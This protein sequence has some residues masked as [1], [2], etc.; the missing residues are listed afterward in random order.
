MLGDQLRKVGARQRRE[1]RGE[2]R[3][4]GVF[5]DAG[6]AVLRDGA[7]DDELSICKP[8]A[9]R[10]REDVAELAVQCA[11]RL[12]RSEEEGSVR[13]AGLDPVYA[14]W[15]FPSRTARPRAGRATA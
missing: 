10:A 12:G 11:L 9:R 3:V 5:V 6:A 8:K 2:A 14:R 13:G 4:D 15:P 1:Q 7:D